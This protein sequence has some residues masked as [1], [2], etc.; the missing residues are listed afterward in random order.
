MTSPMCSHFSDGLGSVARS[1]EKKRSRQINSSS[2]C[3]RA[4]HILYS[5]SIQMTIM[6]FN[7]L[8]ISGH[9]FANCMF[10]FHKIEVETVILR[11]LTGLNLK[12]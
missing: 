10:I 6:Y 9:I 3:E 1:A 12:F 7:I 2:P 5:D 4:L 11:C 8:T